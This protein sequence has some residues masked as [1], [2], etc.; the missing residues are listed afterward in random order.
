MEPAAA[1]DRGAI[2]RGEV[3]AREIGQRLREV[4]IARSEWRGVIAQ[5]RLVKPA[6]LEALEGGE[7]ARLP[8]RHHAAGYARAYAKHLGLDGDGLGCPL[9]TLSGWPTLEPNDR[10]SHRRWRPLEPL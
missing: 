8:S 3:I 5:K 6:E 2:D 9:L 10:Q 4:R 7:L 1:V